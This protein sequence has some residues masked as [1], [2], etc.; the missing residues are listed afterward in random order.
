M[1]SLQ[2]KHILYDIVSIL[3]SEVVIL[4]IHANSH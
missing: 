4:K 1:P 3:P 2:L